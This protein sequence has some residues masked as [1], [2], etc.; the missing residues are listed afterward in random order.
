MH[1]A[2]LVEEASGRAHRKDAFVPDAGMDVDAEAAVGPQRDEVL[3]PKIVAR[4]GDGHDERLAIERKEELA[5]VGMVVAMPQEHAIAA[6]RHA[7][8][9]CFLGRLLGP[10]AEADDIVAA[11]C[12]VTPHELVAA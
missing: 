2:L 5:A 1:P 6:Q 10:L 8:L 3:G 9:G 4:P 7:T 12:L 11:D